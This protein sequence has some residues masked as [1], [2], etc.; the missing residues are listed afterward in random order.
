MKKK[1]VVVGV[2]WHWNGHVCLWSDQL[3]TT[4]DLFGH[5][6]M[7]QIVIYASIHISGWHTG[8]FAMPEFK[9][10]LKQIKEKVLSFII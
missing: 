6:Q 4:H 8:P 3:L 10:L 7:Q 5:V 1:P 2:C 9:S